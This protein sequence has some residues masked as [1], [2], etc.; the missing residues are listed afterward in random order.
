MI[1]GW[2]SNRVEVLVIIP[3]KGKNTIPIIILEKPKK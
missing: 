1:V 3:M 2:V